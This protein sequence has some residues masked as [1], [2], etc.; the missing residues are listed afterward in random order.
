MAKK[1]EYKFLLL[2]GG[3]EFWT[4]NVHSGVITKQQK[5]LNELGDDGWELVHYHHLE[6]SAKC[7]IILKREKKRKE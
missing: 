4:G 6:E 5:Q 2:D 3:M 1:W 7:Q